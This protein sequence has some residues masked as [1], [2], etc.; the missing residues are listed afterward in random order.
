MPVGRRINYWRRLVGAYLIPGRSQLTFWHGRPEVNLEVEAGSLGQYHQLF[1]GK[2]DYPGPYD[3]AG[4][5]KLNYHG[6]I[7]E[8]YNPIAIAQYGLGNYNLYIRSGDAD[9]K[10]NFL[11]IASWLLDN[12]EISPAGTC[13]W[14]HNFDWEY[15]DVLW[16]PWFSALSQGQGLSLLVRAH[17]ETGDQ[18]YA[19]AADRVF[20]TFTRGLN[21]GGV[22]YVGDG[23]TWF[24]EAL[25]EPTTHILNGH[26]WAAW[27]V[28]DYYIH[29]KSEEA[30]KL[31]QAA[32]DTTL[33][34]LERFDTGYWSLYDQSGRR[35]NMLASGF[36]HSLHIVQLRIMHRLT[37]EPAF[38]EWAD[39]WAGFAGRTFN[40]RRAFVHKVVFKLLY[41]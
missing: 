27:G 7:G 11:R 18:R 13:V 30:G 24:E 41:Y 3:S 9:R 23:G 16:S 21:D 39:R 20:E 36:Y 1:A 12:L 38:E 29:T 26:M 2:A 17:A 34:N 14:N 31:W 10:D 5:P 22:T 6:K 35:M 33:D 37:G 15:R 8:Q 40:R 28:Y 4:I 19:T 32:V 25:I